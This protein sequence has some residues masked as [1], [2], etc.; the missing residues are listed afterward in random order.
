MAELQIQVA[1]SL[2][3]RLEVHRSEEC[4]LVSKA[5][6]ENE[7]YADL[8]FFSTL[9]PQGVMLTQKFCMISEVEMFLA[10][11]DICFL[12][13][14]FLRILLICLLLNVMYIVLFCICI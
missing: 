9:V 2:L 10:I 3:N 14:I 5:G 13:F 6:P 7:K 11:P 1:K 8:T 12:C 4:I